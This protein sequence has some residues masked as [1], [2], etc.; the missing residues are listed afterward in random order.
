MTCND[1]VTKFEN[2]KAKSLKSTNIEAIIEF[3]VLRKTLEAIFWNTN[4]A[5]KKT[6]QRD[7]NEVMSMEQSIIMCKTKEG[8]IVWRL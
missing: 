4:E 5:L 1:I 2:I 7:C 6:D 3:F 8:V